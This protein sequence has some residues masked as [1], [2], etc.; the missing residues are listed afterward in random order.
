[1]LCARHANA[2]IEIDEPGRSA[3]MCEIEASISCIRPR[4]RAALPSI[5]FA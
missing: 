4:M 5:P 1:V 2:P 3:W